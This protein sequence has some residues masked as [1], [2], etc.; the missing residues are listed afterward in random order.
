[1]SGSLAGVAGLMLIVVTMT[2]PVRGWA[3]ADEA[4]D[5]FQEGVT[6]LQQGRVPEAIDR[7]IRARDERPTEPAVWWVLGQAYE[8]ARRVS[9]A[10]DAYRRVID[11][12][13]ES[14]EAQRARRR[15]DQLGPDAETHEAVRRDFEAGVAAYGA[16]DLATAEAEFRKVLDRLPKH[17]TS[18]LLLGTI[19]SVS[20]RGD[21]ARARWETAVAAEPGFYPAQVNLGRL[22]DA[23]GEIEKAVIAY[24]A[25]VSTGATSSDVAFAARRLSQLGSTPEQALTVRGW[26]REANEALQTGR[27][28]DARRFFERVLAALPAHAPAGFGAALLAAKRGEVAE[29]MSLLKRGLEGDPDFYPALFLFGEIEAGQGR[30]KEAI[31]YFTRVGELVGPRIEGIEA[32][33]RIP[34][35]EEAVTTQTAL[36]VGFRL[37]ARASFDE[38]IEAFQRREYEPAFQAFGK[39]S[40]LDDQNPYYVF[41]RGLAAYNLNNNVVA[42][43]S[44]E[45]AVELLPTYGLAHFWLALLFQ[46]SAQQARDNGN[47]PEAQAEY[48][49][50]FQKLERAIEHGAQSWF[51]DEA[52]KR[53]AESLDFLQRYQEEAGHLAIGS[54]LVGQGRLLEAVAE[55]GRA[56]ERLPWDFQPWLSLGAINADQGS[57]DQARAAL[58]RALQI[59]PRSPKPHMELGLLFERQKRPDDA[60]AAFRKAAELAPDS[61]LPRISL[62]TLLQ[63]KDDYAGAIT[64]FE[65]VLQIVGGTSTPLVHFRLAFSYN[66]SGQLAL[67][68]KQYQKTLTLLAGRTEQEA[69]DIRNTALERAETI[70]RALR[71]YTINFSVTPWSYDSN[72]NASES[73]PLGGVSTA[74]SGGIN[75]RLIVTEAFQVTGG[76]H[77]SQSYFLVGGQTM[78]TSTSA[79]LS[80]SYQVSPLVGLGGGYSWSYGHGSTGPQTLGQSLNGSVTKRGQLPSSMTFG[81]SYS[82]SQGLGGGTIKSSNIGYSLSLSQSFNTQGSM[83]LSYSA[84][85]SD[86]NRAGQGTRSQNVGLSYSRPLWNVLSASWSYG[87]GFVD[88]LDPFTVAESR[89]GRRVESLV[90]RKGGSQSYGMSLSYVFR[91]DLSVSLGVNV[92]RNTSNLSFDR[93]EDLSE[94]LTNQVRA[95]GNFGKRTASFSVS[96][97]F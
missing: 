35:L 46:A 72:F 25:A 21:E 43:R 51:L 2:N 65:K 27:A 70:E 84:S 50:A 75:Y 81:L 83:S 11:L 85:A 44:F 16:R 80:T 93:P 59:S 36:E 95:G 47:L 56:A 17:L 29:A 63:Q 19:A 42:A 67:A 28:D 62:G 90:S 38:G 73:D 78:N 66:L 68:L 86:S 74:V 1:M 4:P 61:P 60:I 97:S 91:G 18:L 89:G 13:P 55:F 94:L 9:E 34:G 54:A 49:A 33:R 30:F 58:D 53:R 3:Q 57:Y 79:S 6:L 32:R 69:L 71:L 14:D 48:L 64:E 76:L 7:L 23:A 88:Y 20:G 22:Y 40:V 96:K 37:E 92:A 41:N 15:L 8:T 10:I 45:R 39:A 82:L 26:L 24:S 12:A 5:A 77:H 87:V 52:K 31:K